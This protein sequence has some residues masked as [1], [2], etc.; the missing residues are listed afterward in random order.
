MKTPSEL[1]IGER[2]IDFIP[3]G[4]IKELSKHIC[5]IKVCNKNHFC[6][7]DFDHNGDHMSLMHGIKCLIPTITRG[8]CDS[9]KETKFVKAWIGVKGG[10]SLCVECTPTGNSEE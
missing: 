4:E 3:N 9:C 8:K 2:M 7:R 6:S 1:K 10:L 5:F